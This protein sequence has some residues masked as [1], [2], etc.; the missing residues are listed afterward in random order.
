ML[1]LQQNTE[2]RVFISNSGV[3][4]ICNR[5]MPSAWVVEKPPKTCE[6]R[7]NSSGKP[8]TVPNIVE[9]NFHCR[10]ELMLPPYTITMV[11]PKLRNLPARFVLHHRTFG[12]ETD[13]EGIHHAVPAETVPAFHV[14]FERELAWDLVL[15]GKIGNRLEHHLRTAGKHLIEGFPTLN[16]VLKHLYVIPLETFRPVICGNVQRGVWK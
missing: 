9:E 13:A 8:T 11:L 12:A 3:N 4:G 16:Q 2:I 1:H 15:G 6:I 10:L 7:K 5:R 14:P